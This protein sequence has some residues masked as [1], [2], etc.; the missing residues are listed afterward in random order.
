MQ[1][2][3]CATR[4]P[5]L[6]SS[7]ALRRRGDE[8]VFPYR[9]RFKKFLAYVDVARDLDNVVDAFITGLKS[10]LVGGAGL[11]RS[12]CKLCPKFSG[13]IAQLEWNLGCAT[14][15]AALGRMLCETRGVTSSAGSNLPRVPQTANE[16]Q[17]GCPHG[18][19]SGCWICGQDGHN[20]FSCPQRA[21]FEKA[22]PD[23]K[24]PEEKGLWV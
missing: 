2:S 1:A 5:R 24:L 13:A 22:N 7:P 20:S 10:S 19:S 11:L 16:V 4:R 9:D 15:E 17:E 18:N 23:T 21:A 14:N 3:R 8:K 12:T 6:S